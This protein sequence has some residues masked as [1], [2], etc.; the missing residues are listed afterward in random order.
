MTKNNLNIL[1]TYSRVINIWKFLKR[2][3]IE[4][5]VDFSI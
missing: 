3:Y 5:G 2:Q 4:L 1:K